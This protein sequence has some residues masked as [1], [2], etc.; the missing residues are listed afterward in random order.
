MSHSSVTPFLED[1]WSAMLLLVPI[2]G[3]AVDQRIGSNAKIMMN[4]ATLQ[5]SRPV[6]AVVAADSGAH[7]PSTLSNSFV[8]M[9]RQHA[10]AILVAGF[11]LLWLVAATL[12]LR[13]RRLLKSRA[14]LQRLERIR[15]AYDA[16]TGRGVASNSP[17]HGAPLDPDWFS[18]SHGSGIV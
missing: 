1:R 17:V 6:S 11:S 8:L 3:I 4:S 14:Q 9:A 2:V 5:A 7:V 16:R 10:A 13:E 12:Y 18:T 15:A